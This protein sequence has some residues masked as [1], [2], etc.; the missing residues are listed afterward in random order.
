[1]HFKQNL[2]KKLLA[3]SCALAATT[4][5]AAQLEEVMV[6]AT[7]RTQ[8]TMDIPMSVLAVTGDN[9][10]NQGIVDIADI[11]ATIPN[12]SIGTGLSSTFVSIRGMGSGNDSSFE[13]SVGLFIDDMYMP[14]S[15]HYRTAFVDTD[16]VEVLRGSQAVL[17]G[18]NSTAGAISI[19]TLKNRPGD[20]L[21]GYI[22]GTYETEFDT[23]GVEAA[24]GGSVGDTL[25]L[26]LAGK[27]SDGESF[28]DNA[29]TGDSAGDTEF[30]SLRFSLVWEP[31]DQLSIEGKIDT[32]ENTHEGANMSTFEK[33]GSWDHVALSEGN[34]SN[35]YAAVIGNAVLLAPHSASTADEYGF[36]EE[37]TT[38]NVKISY[39]FDGGSILSA[40]LG[41]SD[42]EA[43]LN[44]DLMFSPSPDWSAPYGEEYEQQSFELRFTSADEGA[45]TYIAGIYYHETEMSHGSNNFI[46]LAG[47]GLPVGAVNVG[48]GA[49]RDSDL[50]SPFATV[51]WNATDTLR[52]TLGLRYVEEDKDI[53]RY[54]INMTDTGGIFN[55]FLPPLG[56]EPDVDEVAY[57]NIFTPWLGGPDLF[58]AI[59]G[60]AARSDG[61]TDD[62]N[63][64]NVMGEL[65]VQWDATEDGMAYLKLGNS[66]KSGGW[67]AG[68]QA[69]ADVLPYDDEKAK[70]FEIGYKTMLADGAA[71]MNVAVFYTEYDDLQVNSFNADG[72]P[73]ITNAGTSIS[74]GIELDGRWAATD[75]L[76]LSGSLAFLDSEFDDFK[77]GPGTSTP[78]D[79]EGNVFRAPM[80]DYSGL[81]RPFAPEWSGNVWV[82]VNQPIT[83]SMNF[84]GGLGISFSDDYYTEG[85]LDPEG[86]Q[87]SW[88]KVDARLGLESADGSWRV[89][90]IG[91][92]LTDEE[93]TNTYQYFFGKQ[94]FLQAP[95][96]LAVQAEYRFGS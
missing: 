10:V 24:I 63:S 73:S 76:M 85:S 90:V 77:N 96:T 41:Y 95:R 80:S 8:T 54:A 89:S 42:T 27:F 87:D 58:K 31:S 64:D 18:L 53:E 62:R 15:A 12:L 5:G 94:A 14:R 21:E 23:A 65:L 56:F 79:E 51:T 75:W 69:E 46:D 4:A 49:D 52:A 29:N 37:A 25:G 9:L 50:L 17:F 28:Y 1:M 59:V 26:R 67:G 36:F 11:A 3:T 6:T 7:K 81:D 40:M 44:Q 71:E 61:F 30:E 13:Q 91:K 84:I 60:F 33:N 74:Q 43:E 57:D 32:M 38:A 72:D 22:R 70:T 47:F 2:G 55:D 16:R 88:T 83:S 86:K 34:E 68:V 82:D 93:I 66:A 48:S 78:I 45:F 92:N 19:H 39:E 20:E 35:S